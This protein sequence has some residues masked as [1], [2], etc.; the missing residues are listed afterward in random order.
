M[1]NTN[2]NNINT[3]KPNFK[4]LDASKP[5]KALHVL[6]PDKFD[7]GFI[8]L[9]NELQAICQKEKMQLVCQTM[10]GFITDASK[11]RINEHIGG[12]PWLQDLCMQLPKVEE[13]SEKPVKRIFYHNCF[14][15]DNDI[16]YFAQRLAR[17]TDSSLYRGNSSLSNNFVGGNIYQ[18]R[19]KWGYKCVLIGKKC[20]KDLNM[21]SMYKIFG[22]Q[23]VAFVPQADFHIDL[24]LRPLKN[25]K[26]LV[27]DDEMSLKFLK[28]IEKNLDKFSNMTPEK[29]LK[30]QQFIQETK[31]NIN[32]V[33][34]SKKIASTNDVIKFLE[35][36]NFEVVRVP[37]RFYETTSTKN[38]IELYHNANYMNSIVQQREDGT[39]AYITNASNPIYTGGIRLDN[40]F[41]KYLKKVCPEIKDV[42]FVSGDN[43]ISFDLKYK[44]GGMHCRVMEEVENL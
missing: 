24:F 37:G 44:R 17:Y 1:I 12:Y 39:L 42:Y 40:L 38:N 27:A 33:N 43:M 31:K 22:T 4:G 30:F 6:A 20:E 13:N 7:D 36:K 21:D 16:D 32:T 35:N 3:Y 19:N 5:L 9:M 26:I 14:S 29:K 8:T 18:G 41:A 10:N 15:F 34:K 28:F 25:G 2:F 23:D 11:L